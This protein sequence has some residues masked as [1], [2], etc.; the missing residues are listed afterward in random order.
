MATMSRRRQGT[1][2]ARLRE[3]LVG[4]GFVLIPMAVFL[5]FFIYPFFYALYISRFD[6]GV[7]GKIETLGLENYRTLL[8]DELFWRGLKNTVLY[9]AAVVPIQM[10]LG[11]TVAVIV[12]AGIRGARSS[13]RRSTSPRS[14]PPPRSPRSR[15]TSF[16]PT[17]S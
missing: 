10:A 8:D 15:S 12:N 7:F 6:W 4:Y 11:L 9:T 16:R 1:G 17:G 13:A 14:P 5:T 3:A 2:N